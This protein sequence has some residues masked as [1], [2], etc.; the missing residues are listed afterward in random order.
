MLIAV[1]PAYGEVQSPIYL[2]YSGLAVIPAANE[3][4]FQSGETLWGRSAEPIRVRL[5]DAS[6][7]EVNST[8]LGASPVRLWSFSDSDAEGAWLILDDDGFVRS[9][10]THERVK[11]RDPVVSFNLLAIGVTVRIPEG[12][13]YF[14]LFERTGLPNAYSPGETIDLTPYLGGSTPN[15][16]VRLSM[17]NP[18]TQ[19]SVSESLRQS[20]VFD[21][22]VLSRFI[23]AGG[24]YRVTLPSLHEV[25]SGGL[26]PL[27][28]GQLQVTL[29][30]PISAI[31]IN[32]FRIFV[33]PDSVKSA[34]SGSLSDSL[35][36][37]FEAMEEEV[38][39]LTITG[40]ESDAQVNRRSF[41]LPVASGEL[42]NIRDSQPIDQFTLQIPN[43]SS[44]LH[45]GISYILYQSKANLTDLNNSGAVERNYAV[46]INGFPSP[47]HDP[48]TL[49]LSPGHHNI[50]FGDAASLRLTVFYDPFFI[51][52]ALSA[53]ESDPE[54]L[55]GL[56]EPPTILPT[57][58]ISSSEGSNIITASNRTLVLPPGLY[59]F[60]LAIGKRNVTETLR[61]ERDGVIELSLGTGDSELVSA[62]K[63]AAAVQAVALSS[64]VGFTLYRRWRYRIR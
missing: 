12:S 50:L 57:V 54:F 48:L 64:L 52:E 61:L 11:W 21:P 4:T 59:N 17:S 34:V 15:L 35:T 24:E 1:L 29:E 22:I 8:I 40:S 28:Y 38:N 19:F 23:P 60:T 9:K 7:D 43:S 58:R 27:R 51:E 13:E 63:I 31:L 20:I 53:L 62:L 39:L 45:E 42:R 16:I 5:L 49:I 6:G 55:Q 37:R 41:R 33:L 10:I 30:D 3:L 56:T 44:E 14:G 47:V 32:R 26:M 36:V 2:G 46:L 25:K 18:I